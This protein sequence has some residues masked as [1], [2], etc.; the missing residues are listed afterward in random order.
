MRKHQKPFAI[1]KKRR[2]RGRR[3]PDGDS[4]NARAR[5]LD[6]EPRP[7]AAPANRVFASAA[8]AAAVEPK[9]APNRI[10]PDLTAP[11]RVL[12]VRAE[13]SMSPKE[14]PGRSTMAKLPRTRK[15]QRRQ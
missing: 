7:A 1:E 15:S 12:P 5:K 13:V 14:R 8:H 4:V 9:P 11:E 6:L 10:L 2:I 3:H